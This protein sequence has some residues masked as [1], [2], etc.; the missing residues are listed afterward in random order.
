[1]IR[2]L[3]LAGV[4]TCNS[5]SPANPLATG[6]HTFQSDGLSLWYRVAGPSQGIPVIY[7]H[8]GPAEGS[9]GLAHTSGPLLERKLRIVYFDQRGAGHSARP[10]DAAR[11]T[12]AA[13]V[14]DIERLR[15][16]LGVP[17]IALLGHSYGSILALEYAALHPANVSR[18]VLIGTVVDQRAALNLEC[19]RLKAEDAGAYA[20]AVKAADQPGDPDCIPMEGVKGPARQAY[21]LRASGARPGTLE[22]LD[23]SDAAE[24]V[25]MGGPAHVSLAE[26]EFHYRFDQVAKL[27]MPV[28]VIAGGKDRLTDPAPVRPFV[29]ALPRGRMITYPDAGHFLYVDE[30]ARFARDA[31]AFLDH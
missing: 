19:Q 16:E 18:M 17:K 8:G 31:T 5:P 28:L 6:P 3:L 13:I 29:A 21:F 27:T 7:L 15:R 24:K 22:K 10:D 11:Y 14:E 12:M 26:P 23:A 20:L 25:T 4:L 9:Q 30:A 2:A 1:M